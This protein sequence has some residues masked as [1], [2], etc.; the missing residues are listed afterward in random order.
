MAPG[1][2]YLAHKAAEDTATLVQL[3]PADLR[4][5]PNI[6]ALTELPKR[7][8]CEAV[9]KELTRGVPAR[10]LLDRSDGSLHPKNDRSKLAAPDFFSSTPND[11][12]VAFISHRWAAEPSDTVQ[13]LHMA[14]ILRYAR[15]FIRPQKDPFLASIMHHCLRR[16]PKLQSCIMQPGP[17]PAFFVFLWLFAQPFVFP[18]PLLYCL[19]AVSLPYIFLQ[20]LDVKSKTLGRMIFF[21]DWVSVPGLWFDKACVHQTEPCLNQAGIALFP[22][23]LEK[24]KELWILFTPEYLTRVWCIY[25]LATWLKTKPDAPVFIVPLLRSARL[26]RSVLRWWPWVTLVLVSF[27]GWT[28]FGVALMHQRQSAD[29]RSAFNV[30]ED[31]RRIMWGVIFIIVI[32]IAATFVGA[33]FLIVWPLR[34]ERL[35]IAEQLKEFDVEDCEAFLEKDKDYVLGLVA[36]WFGEAGDAESDQRAAALRRFNELVRTRVARRLRRSLLMSEAQLAAFFLLVTLLVFFYVAI[37]VEARPPPVP[38]PHV[39][40]VTLLT[41]EHSLAQCVVQMMTNSLQPLVWPSLHSELS[42]MV[43]TDECMLSHC[44]DI[45]L[46]NNIDLRVINET[47]WCHAN[48][49]MTMCKGDHPPLLPPRSCIWAVDVNGFN[50]CLV[51]YCA[52]WSLA[53]CTALHARRWGAQVMKET[54]CCL[55]SGAGGEAK[56]ATTAKVAAAPAVPPGTVSISV[57]VPAGASAGAKIQIQHEGASYDVT[58]PEGVAEGQEFVVALPSDPCAA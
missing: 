56:A 53:L 20:F 45:I 23:Y 42:R 49:N 32:V 40:H 24:V 46:H 14:L 33:Y 10:M 54:K 19:F 35:R 36:E 34:K 39:P 48:L 51:G 17:G 27:V 55:F 4:D 31:I 1:A 41:S 38:L 13:G 3:M 50:Y 5:D 37:I 30:A 58:V 15:L 44:C 29:T 28:V 16:C 22:Y 12:L 26:Y 47:D 11:D 18:L 52:V 7:K 57:A 25:E 43:N 9:L 2:D 6:P 8:D 21:N